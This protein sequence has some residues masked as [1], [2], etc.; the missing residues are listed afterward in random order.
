MEQISS[1]PPLKSYFLGMLTLL[2][3]LTAIAQDT[4]VVGKD[5]VINRYPTRAEME[6]KQA[7][8]EQS[9]FV[10]PLGRMDS[11][12]RIMVTGPEQNCKDAI[13]VCV[14]T[15]TQSTSYTGVGTI[16]E[17]KNCCLKSGEKNSV[18]YVFTTQTA[19]NFGFTIN[20][21]KD[22]DFAIYD[23]TTMGCEGVPTATPTVCNYSSTKGQ[24][25]MVSGGGASNA[26]PASGLPFCGLLAV[27]AGKT[28]VL[29]VSNY[30]GDAT[31]YTLTFTVGGGYTSITDVVPPTLSSLTNNCDN[32]VTIT[33]SEPVKCST[34][35]ADGSD[36][37]ISG[38]GTIT[39][40]AG[41]GCSTNGYVSQILVTYTAPST[42]TYTLGI[43]NGSDGNTLIDKCGNSM[44]TSQTITFNYLL[45]ALSASP[46]SVCTAGSAVV[47][48][49]TGANAGGTYT[50]TP[51]GTSNTTGTF[52][53]NPNVTTT[54]VVTVTYGGCTKTA[55]N[56]VG[57]LSNV[58]ATIYPINPTICSG[59]TTLTASATVNGTS[60][61]TCTYSWSPGGATTAAITVGSG[62]YT[63]TVVKPGS[64]CNATASSTVNLVSAGGGSNCNI[65]YVS[66]TGTGTGFSPSDPTSIDAALDA[67]TCAGAIIKMQ[68]GNYNLS[69]K[70]TITSYTTME[71]GYNSTFTTK[72][73]D[74]QSGNATTLVRDATPD[75]G[76][77]TNVTTI[78]AGASTVG[79]RIQDIRIE[80]A[81]EA[82]G[83]QLT[84]YG[85]KLGASCSGYKIVRCY[86]DAG[87]GSD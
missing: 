4:L 43:K 68:T 81:D 47:L 45:L 55:T 75:G 56:S 31:G 17:V 50:L 77:G 40:A 80:M 62:T 30:T 65:Y 32:T 13:P 49:A 53:V 86:I 24:T 1:Q 52:N 66:P 63:V 29:I 54:Y 15:Y 37:T 70:L 9:K 11:L 12:M 74:M 46:A 42:G 35:A 58:V 48:T 39:A 25:G 7:I 84:N 2:L 3:S 23:I 87:V 5:T 85:I 72:T 71:G 57:V 73:S 51:G 14:Q 18:W 22:Y 28:Y 33:L 21:V 79:F 44:S 69:D 19:G 82:A 83:A 78:E 10:T 34:I 41:V 76:T 59:T 60:C 26:E 38:S 67:A 61:P 27:S 6:E 8:M 16:D 64:T 20:T 36:F